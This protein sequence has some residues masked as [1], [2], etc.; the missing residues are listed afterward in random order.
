MV[1]SDFIKTRQT[2]QNNQQ[3]WNWLLTQLCQICIYFVFLLKNWKFH[4]N[5]PLKKMKCCKCLALIRKVQF[6]YFCKV[7]PPWLEIFGGEIVCLE[8]NLDSCPCGRKF[9]QR[10]L[11][12]GES[13]C[14]GSQTS[15]SLGKLWIQ[16]FYYRITIGENL[17]EIYDIRPVF[18]IVCKHLRKRRKIQ[19]HLK[20]RMK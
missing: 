7:K 17:C 12:S 14:S 20:K 3:M 4:F 19:M 18:Y 9:L 16:Q 2:K 11:V 10:F 15:F 5:W 13:S 1:E 6:L 8:L